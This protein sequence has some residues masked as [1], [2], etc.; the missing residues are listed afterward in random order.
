MTLYSLG[1]VEPQLPKNDNYW[2]ADSAQVIGRVRLEAMTSIWFGAILRGD[3]EPISI[4]QGSNVQDGSVLHTDIGYP[5]SIGKNCTIGHMAML[6]GCKIEDGV[7]VGMKATILNGARIGRNSVVGAC[8]LVT[9]GKEIPDNSLFVGS[10]ARFVRTIS[11]EEHETFLE[12][13][14]HYHHNLLKYRMSLKPVG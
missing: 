1:D 7:L 5:L 9:E 12:A 6:H 3:N 11:E 4:G 2:V 8:S 13:A 10:P 14:K